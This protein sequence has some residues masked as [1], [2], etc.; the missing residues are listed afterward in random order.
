MLS[1]LRTFTI[2]I[3][4]KVF[5]SAFEATIL[6]FYKANNKFFLFCDENVALP[7]HHHYRYNGY[8]DGK[9]NGDTTVT[10]RSRHKKFTVV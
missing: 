7:L 9:G 5:R 10:L 6:E 2:H 1:F 4:E 8:V 3:E